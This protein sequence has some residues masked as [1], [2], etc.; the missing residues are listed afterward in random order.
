MPHQNSRGLLRVFLSV[1]SFTFVF[2]SVAAASSPSIAAA[3]PAAEVELIC[4]TDNQAECYPKVF[5]PT[6][7]FQIIHHDQDIPPGLHVRMNIWTGEKEARL[8][9]PGDDDPSLEG[10]PVEQ[11]VMVVEAEGVKNEPLMPS[12]APAYEPVGVVKEPPQKDPGFAGS[13]ASLKEFA[14][15]APSTQNHQLDEALMD[16]EDISHDIYYGQKITEDLEALRAL[17]C[18]LTQ[19]DVEQIQT[20]GLTQRRDFLASSVLASAAQNNPPALRNIEAGWDSLMNK[21]CAFHQQPLKD[22]FFDSFK[23]MAKPGTEEYA[24]EAS[25]VRTTLPVVGRLLKSDV[26][27]TQFLANGGTKNFLRVLLN[28]G[29]VWDAAR[30]KVAMIVSDTFLDGD[31][32]AE[33]GVWPVGAASDG[34]IC[35]NEATRLDDGCWEYHLEQLAIKNVWGKASGNGWSQDLLARLKQS[36]PRVAGSE[37]IPERNEL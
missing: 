33:L 28:D 30:S 29:A 34:N 35:E 11:S 13:L 17:F 23:T 9:I 14:E 31:V 27:R 26:F 8:N 15:T 37:P 25:W 10:L 12:G 3:S 22:V 16:L 20:R 24:N 1:I 6:E 5:S 21:Q 7:E 36:R 4:H 19:R 2:A 32:G 18:L